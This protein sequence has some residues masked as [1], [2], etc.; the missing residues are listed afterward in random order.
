M[1]LQELLF[2]IVYP[3]LLSTAD[4]DVTGTRASK[5]LPYLFSNEIICLN[6]NADELFLHLLFIQG[7]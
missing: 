5:I 4:S 6:S 1:L 2:L 7:D 3:E